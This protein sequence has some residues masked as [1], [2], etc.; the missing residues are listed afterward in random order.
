ME[1]IFPRNVVSLKAPRRRLISNRPTAAKG[2]INAK[3]EDSGKSRLQCIL[4]RGRI[5]QND[6][7][8]RIRSN[9]RKARCEGMA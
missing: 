7:A 4:L 3:P 8:E 6:T 1:S 2:P 9:A 5:S